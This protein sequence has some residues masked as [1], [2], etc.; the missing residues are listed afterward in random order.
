[1]RNESRLADAIILHPTKQM[2]V[3]AHQNSI[4]FWN[5]NIPELL[6][7]MTMKQ[8]LAQ[9]S[10]DKI[11]F[12]ELEESLPFA[13]ILDANDTPKPLIEGGDEELMFNFATFFHTKGSQTTNPQAKSRY[14]A[15]AKML[16]EALTKVAFLHPAHFYQGILE[17]IETE[18]K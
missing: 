6:E 8:H 13:H 3:A 7:E 16:Y 18:E 17:K 12:Y 15:K 11:E 2:M 9:L 5:F 1:L 4:L 14:L 10:A